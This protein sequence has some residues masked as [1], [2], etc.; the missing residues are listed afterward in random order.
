MI[1]GLVEDDYDWKSDQ[2]LLSLC[3]LLLAHLKAILTHF[4][5]LQIA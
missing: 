4:M 5:I 3:T 2:F 1:Y